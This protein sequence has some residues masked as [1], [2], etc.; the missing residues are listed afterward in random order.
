MKTWLLIAVAS[1][2]RLY[3]GHGG[4]NDDLRSVYR[5]DSFVPNYKNLSAGDSVLIRDQSE[6]RGSAVIEAIEAERGTKRRN[7]CPTCG[8]TKLKERRQKLPRYRCECGAEFDAPRP[9]SENCTLFAAHFGSSFQD[10]RGTISIK[11]LWA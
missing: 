1:S 6:V 3:R 4:Y 10:L 11:Q 9:R 5:Y 2:E 8:A 7:L